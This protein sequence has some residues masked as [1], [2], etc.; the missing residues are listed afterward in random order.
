M[1]RNIRP[2]FNFEPPATEDEVHAAAL[3][4]VRKISGFSKPSKANEEAFN[5]ALGLLA[6]KGRGVDHDY[7]HLHYRSSATLLAMG[8]DTFVYDADGERL[9]R[10]AGGLTTLYP[11]EDYEIA[12]SGVATKYFKLGATTVAKRVGTTTYW[13]HTD[14]LGSIQA[15][16][17]GSGKQFFHFGGKRYSH[18]IDPRTGW[19]AQGMMSVTVVCPSG[20]VADALATGMF[21]MGVPAAIEFC[22]AHP[23]IAAILIYQDAKSGAQRI[24]HRNWRQVVE[25]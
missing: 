15:S 22:D 16:T 20:A 18:L 2:L 5:A 10:T 21:I 8:A 9:K 12:S 19:P 17:S 4:F 7:F 6:K 14:H 1:C 23:S 3:Q 25:D 11:G 13:L 24:E